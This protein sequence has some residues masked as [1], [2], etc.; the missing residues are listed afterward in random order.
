ANRPYRAIYLVCGMAADMACVPNGD[1]WGE[2]NPCSAPNGRFYP[3]PLVAYGRMDSLSV[4]ITEWPTSFH[5]SDRPDGREIQQLNNTQDANLPTW[6]PDGQW[7]YFSDDVYGRFYRVRW[8]GSQQ[9][10]L[11]ITHSAG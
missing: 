6:S 8:D 10:A 11:P 4:Q 3:T 2:P 5:L 7:V 1:R 9:E